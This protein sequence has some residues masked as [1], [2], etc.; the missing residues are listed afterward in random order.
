MLL[1]DGT[2]RWYD[3]TIQL[4]VFANGRAGLYAEHALIDATVISR[5]LTDALTQISGTIDEP[6]APPA[7]P[8]QKLNFALDAKDQ[9]MITSAVS[10]YSD[11]IGQHHV[12]TLEFDTYGSSQIKKL[13]F[14]PDAFV[15]MSIQYAYRKVSGHFG[16]TYDSV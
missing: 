9:K 15:Q 2:N 12:H 11:F 10:Y 8:P 1:D 13:G 6:T 4:I 7:T 16:A 5:I 3:K 14:S